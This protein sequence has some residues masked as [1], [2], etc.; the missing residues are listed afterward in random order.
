[1]AADDSLFNFGRVLDVIH[2]H[3]DHSAAEILD[4]LYQT[5]LDFCYPLRPLDD[6]TGVIVKVNTVTDVGTDY[7]R[8]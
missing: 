5:V 4:I 1:M 3:R 8:H 7:N 6:I 2:A